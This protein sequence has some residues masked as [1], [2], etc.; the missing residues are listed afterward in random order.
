MQTKKPGAVK[1]NAENNKLL[2]STTRLRCK[3][4]G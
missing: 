2:S 4:T 1:V 3:E